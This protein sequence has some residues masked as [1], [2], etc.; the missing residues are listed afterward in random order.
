VKS[1][2]LKIPPLAVVVLTAALMW[3]VSRLPFAFLSVPA[4]LPFA[5]LFAVAG[6]LVAALG[7]VQF[8]RIGTTVNPLVPGSASSLVISGIYRFTRNPIYLGFLLILLGW[9]IWLSN[10]LSFLCLPG[11]VFYMSRFQI[12]PEERALLAN[13]GHDFLAYKASTRRWL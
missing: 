5:I 7:F 10:G 1:L 2:E 6:I 12:Q 11:F 3:L 9:A 8:R 13:F 4:R